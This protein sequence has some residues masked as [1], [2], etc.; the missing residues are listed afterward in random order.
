MERESQKA[1][2]M[3]RIIVDTN[4]IFS[5]LLNS[6]GTIGYL[7][8]NSDN[9]FEFFSN[10]YMRYE[11]RKHWERILKI[12]KLTEFQLETSYDKLLAK[13]NFVNEELIPADI[14]Q[15]SEGLVAGIDEDDIDFVALTSFLKGA[16]WTGDKIL[17]GG[18]KAKLFR[19]IYNTDD[20]MKLR[21]KLLE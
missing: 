13:L 20:L 19:T 11:I 6:Q 15:K 10:E 9:I 2:E 16:L 17:Y 1:V 21:N 14:W 7:I 4:I 18:L 5:C 12:S 3:K 8:F